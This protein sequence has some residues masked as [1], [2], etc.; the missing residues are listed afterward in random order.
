MSEA[1][2]RG[3]VRGWCDAVAASPFV[4]TVNDAAKPPATSPTWWTIEW[5]A[6][7][8]ETIAYCDVRQETGV[9]TVIAAGEPAMGDAGVAAKLDA[10]VAELMANVDPQ[11][12]FVIERPGATTEHSAGT[13]DRWYRL[14]TPLAYRFVTAAGG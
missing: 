8:L 11:S 9:L 5:A 2:K 14:A 3:L 6:D 4:P 1:Y 13:A 10:I 12:R 7:E